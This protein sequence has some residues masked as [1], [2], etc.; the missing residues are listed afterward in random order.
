MKKIM[1]LLLSVLMVLTMTV[2]AFAAD[3]VTVGANNIDRISISNVLSQSETSSGDSQKVYNL[4]TCQ[5]PAVVTL[6]KDGGYL[7]VI[8]G[9]GEMLA[10][11][12]MAPEDAENGIYDLSLGATY[13]LEKPGYYSVNIGL[14]TWQTDENNANRLSEDTMLVVVQV[15]DGE[16]AAESALVAPKNYTAYSTTSR[17]LVNGTEINFEAYNIFDNNYFKLRDIAMAISGTDKQFDVSWDAATGAVA[18]LSGQTYKAVGGELADGDGINKTAINGTSNITKDGVAVS[19]KAYMINDNNYFKL[20][21]LGQALDFEVSWDGTNNCILIDT[22]KP[23]TGADVP[24]PA[25][26][27]IVYYEAYPHVPDYGAI[28]DAKPISEGPRTEAGV[29]AYGYTYAVADITQEESHAFGAAMSK[30]GYSIK[31][32]QETALIFI[33]DEGKEVALVAENNGTEDV[34]YIFI[35]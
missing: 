34:I 26:S 15:V 18:L 4:Y 29:T 17:V 33:N 8:S 6:L 19:L 31:S 16:T 28:A 7:A 5:A 13:T 32:S 27:S 12:G 24:A 3:T 25:E 30:A 9:Y 21:D 22:T 20:R 1:A 2:S 35:F 11:D 23:Y 14:G 10:P